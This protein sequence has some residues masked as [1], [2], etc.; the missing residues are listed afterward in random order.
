MCSGF[1]GAGQLKSR[2]I[3]TDRISAHYGIFQ[4]DPKKFV[5]VDCDSMEGR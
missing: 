4:D 1:F 3:S 2:K 5:L